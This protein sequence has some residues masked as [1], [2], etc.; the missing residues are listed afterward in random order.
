ML[1][2]VIDRLPDG[3]DFFRLF[4]RDRQF[5]LVLKL[6]DKF[7]GIQRV[8]V[9]IVDEMGFPGDLAF[10]NA[11][12]LAD[13]LDDLLLSVVHN[14][15]CPDYML[16]LRATRPRSENYSRMP[17]VCNACEK[18]AC[19]LLFVTWADRFSTINCHK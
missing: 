1:L 2:D 13:N 3:L 16:N 11:H 7:H 19:S 5:K 10:I 8:S 4:I 17:F 15:S 6:H 12:L 18:V 14:R 9:E